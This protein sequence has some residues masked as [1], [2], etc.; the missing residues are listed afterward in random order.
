MNRIIL[1]FAISTI[2]FLLI[3]LTGYT[4]V[5][6]EEPVNQNFESVIIK[7]QT[8][9]DDPFSQLIYLKRSDNGQEIQSLY[10]IYQSSQIQYKPNDKVIVTTY[11]DLNGNLEYSVIDFVRKDSLLWLFISF[12]IAILLIS[13]KQGLGSLAGMVFSF[14]V[15]LKYVLP[16]ILAGHNPINIAIIGSTII[17][18]ITFILSH[19]PN[20]KTL[21][22]AT[23]TIITLIITSILASVYIQAVKL[24][25][26]A[27]EEA[28]F[29]NIEYGNINFQ[30]LL[31]AGI[32]ISSLGILD[33]ITISQSAIVSEIH[34]TN[35]KLTPL[36]I[37]QK[38]MSIGR[39]HIASTVNTLVLVYTGASLPLLLLFT[40]DSRPFMEVINYEIVADEIV[41]TLVG[42]IGLVLAVPIT[43]LIAV[44][45]TKTKKPV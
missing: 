9:P 14:L 39:D 27:T 41:R 43:T 1:K 10:Q 6:A 25:G 31:L 13:K 3:S 8:F 24:T 37:Y 22:A 29:L 44:L 12:V 4:N 36:K 40:T 15:I 42:S 17:I 16:Q 32:I 35:P 5:F 18:P 38:A 20:K 2:F 21:I 28:N 19:G 23:S 45:Q 26:F 34:K 30:G 11:E 7:I 33:D